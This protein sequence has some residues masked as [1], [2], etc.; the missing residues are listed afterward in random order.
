MFKIKQ[1]PCKG[2]ANLIIIAF[3]LIQSYKYKHIDCI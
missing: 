2:I 3:K 1:E